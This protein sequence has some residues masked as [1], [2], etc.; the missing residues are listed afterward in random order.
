M[1][2]PFLV[3]GAIAVVDRIEGEVAVLEWQDLTFA[4]VPVEVLPPGVEEGDRLVLHARSL[5]PSSV[6]R[7]SGTRPR[8]AVR[9]R[10]RAA[11]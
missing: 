2:V 7:A 4:E 9:S 1:T 11:D 5:P 8:G 6:A 3:F 10:V